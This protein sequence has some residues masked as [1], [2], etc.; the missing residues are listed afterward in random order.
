[1][2]AGAELPKYSRLTRMGRCEGLEHAHIA[3]RGVSQRRSASSSSVNG[4]L[5]IANPTEADHRP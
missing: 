3:A 2:R 4:G 5:R 1:M